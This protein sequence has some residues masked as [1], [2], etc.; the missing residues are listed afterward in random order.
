MAL[1][2]SEAAV[3]ITITSITDGL[4]F[5]IGSYTSIFAVRNFCLNAAVSIF[6]NYVY[7]VT[8]FAALMV[9]GGWLEEA[10]RNAFCPCFSTRASEDDDAQ[11]SCTSHVHYVPM[12][13][14]A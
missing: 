1:T 8:F 7:Q 4:S 12:E 6:F 3:A 10:N 14:P 13:D 11:T 9:V 2:L 5:F